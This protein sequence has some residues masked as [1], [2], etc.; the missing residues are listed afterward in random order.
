MTVTFQLVNHTT[1]QSGNHID[2]VLQYFRM[3]Y[4][5][6]RLIQ[7]NQTVFRLFRCSAM[8]N[9]L[10]DIV[11]HVT[12]EPGFLHRRIRIPILFRSVTFT[13][14]FEIQRQRVVADIPIFVILFSLKKLR[15]ILQN[16]QNRTKSHT[17][18]IIISQR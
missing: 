17:S 5:V 9:I 10:P 4:T 8:N 13:E 15:I 18:I 2:T 11:I 3:P 1:E 14:Q 12:G 6:H 7:I 16:F